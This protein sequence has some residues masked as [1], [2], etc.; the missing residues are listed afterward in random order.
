MT[1]I[2]SSDKRR[3][4]SSTDRSDS[5]DDSLEVEKV[6]P[7]LQ[8]LYPNAEV[9]DKPYGPYGI[10]VV[11]RENGQD[12]LWVELERSMGWVG[13]FRYPSVSFLERKFHFVEEAREKGAKFAMCWFERNHEQFVTAQ[14]SVIEQY[15]PFE[16]TL[17]SGRVDVVR[18]I[19]IEDCKFY[20]L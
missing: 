1:F 10:D 9:L 15:E 14:G 2:S 4:G 16:K 3:Y 17:R 5:F 6:T 7:T 8:A 13:E 20:S 11:V 12:I 18:H 19:D